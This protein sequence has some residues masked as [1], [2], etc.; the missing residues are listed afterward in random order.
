MFTVGLT[1]G[2]ASGKSAA[3]AA[4]DRLGV[5]VS[6]ADRIGR[7]LNTPGQSGLKALVQAL[8]TGILDAQGQLD[9]ASLR[10]RIFA[11]PALRRQVDALLHPLILGALAAEL[12]ACPGP[13]AIAVIPLLVESPASQALVDRVLVV[14][15]PEDLQIGRL[16]SRDGDSLEQAKAI[17]SAQASR[18]ARLAVADDILL[19][20]SDL[21][22]LDAAVERLHGFYRELAARGDPGAPGLRLP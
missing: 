2:I 17:L 11:E 15:S 7:K 18:D 13:Y 9:R 21:A 8:G 19:N 20:A 14:D 22:A 5:P 10:R 6:D 12:A 3:A 16:M 4:F 1:G